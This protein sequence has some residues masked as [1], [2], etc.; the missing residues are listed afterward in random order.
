[1]NY[2]VEETNAHSDLAEQARDFSAEYTA[3][4]ATI[5]IHE[6]K[7][8]LSQL[9]KRAAAGETVYI[10]AYGKPEVMLTAVNI[11]KYQAELRKQ[12]LGCMKGKINLPEGWDDPLPDDIIDLFYSMQGLEDFVKK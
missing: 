10:G 2:N 6:A 5:P 11:G 4:P 8:T 7:S 1:M 3:A 9:V 12:A